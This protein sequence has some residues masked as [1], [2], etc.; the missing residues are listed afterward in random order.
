VVNGKP[1]APKLVTL[2]VN[3]IGVF[4]SEPQ[5]LPTCARDPITHILI[6]AISRPP[7]YALRQ[8]KPHIWCVESDRYDRLSGCVT[9][10]PRLHY[11]E[12][13]I[14][15]S[16]NAASWTGISKAT[17]YTASKH[18]VLGLM[19]ALDSIVA[20]EDIRIAVIHPWFAGDL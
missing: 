17:Q 12:K 1:V 8:A 18:G 6:I 9:W 19:R 11:T 20:E 14:G 16:T 2:E 10:T 4:Y 5:S 15:N 13:R 7:W 3:L